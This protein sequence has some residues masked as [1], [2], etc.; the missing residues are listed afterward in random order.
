RWLQNRSLKL[1]E[2][3]AAATNKNQDTELQKTP[4]VIDNYKRGTLLVA[5]GTVLDEE[6]IGILK[7]QFDTTEESV[8]IVERVLRV[9][10]VFLLVLVLVG[11]NGFYLIHNE[12]RL[13]SSVE[14]LTVFLASVTIAIVLSR[15]LS[16][17]PWRAEVVPLLC[18]VMMLAIAYNQVLAALTGISMTL[19]LTLATGRTVGEFVVIMS[20]IAASVVPLNQVSKRMKLVVVGL[21]AAV[22]YLL[23]SWGV[24]ILESQH[25][26]SL[27]TNKHLVMTSLQGAGWCF[28]TGILASGSLPFVEQCFGVVTDMSL[29]ELSDVSNPLLQELVQRAPGTYSHSNG[30]AAISETAADAIGAN[31]LL[32]RVGAYYH[33]VGKM[34]KPH[35]FV[36]NMTAG[37]V[38]RHESLNPAMSALVIIGHVKDG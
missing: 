12:S 17:G 3:D 34:L 5:P 20:A 27:M 4:P 10:T 18:V 32:C 35:Y 11:M 33:D 8:S 28:L 26:D 25:L 7:A 23:F 15:L 9:G 16:F 1:L 2:F 14:R 36:E 6:T 22:A 13:T 37:Q 19:V 31:G 29:L 24:S 21:C 30:V 38:S